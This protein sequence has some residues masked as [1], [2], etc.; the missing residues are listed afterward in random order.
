MKVLLLGGGARE[1]AIARALVHTPE[2]EL[3]TIS[4]TRN[5]GIQRISKTFDVADEAD[6]DAV[7]PRAK[8]WKVEW[9]VIGPEAPLAAGLADALAKAGVRVAA[10][11]RAAAEI[12]TSKAF[13]RRLLEKHKVP[14]TLKF[15]YFESAEDAK[16]Q[17]KDGNLRYAIKP[18]GLTGGKGVKVYGDHFTTFA[19]GAAYIDEVVSKGA[20]GKAVLLEQLVE[21]EEFTLQAFTDGVRVVS[22]IAVQDHKRLLEG[23]EGPNTGGMG[24]YSQADGLLPF[25]PAAQWE[26]S[27]EILQGIVGALKAEGRPYVGPIYG[28]FMLT[29]HGP[30]IIE[31]NAR[32]GD[33]EAMNVLALLH[34]DYAELV[35]RMAEGRLQGSSASFERLASVVKYIVPPGYGTAPQAGIEVRVDEAAIEAAGAQVYYANVDAVSPGVVKTTTSRAVAVLGRGETIQ[36]AND[37]CEAGVRH[38]KGKGLLVRHDIGTRALI[39]RRLR[40]MQLLAR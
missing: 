34:S 13:M 33:P 7:L 24:S 39:Q 1:H 8:K 18:I 14:G 35:R 15:H 2:V 11:T 28:Q 40:H 22:T 29:P 21:G 16:R 6:I 3:H 12:E 36:E 31:V 4:K 26:R 38:V 32:L 27:L 23:D 37:V 10:P 5:P 25:L 17:L 30:R 19:E 9:A 20:G